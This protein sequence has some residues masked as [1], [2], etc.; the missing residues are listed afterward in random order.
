MQKKYIFHYDA[1]HAWLEVPIKDLYH[2]GVEDQI[3]GNSFRLYINAYL[4]QDCDANV[5]LGAAKSKGWKI[6]IEE[7]D[8]GDESPIR[9]YT[10]YQG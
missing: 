4:E 3:S 2:A 9:K 1:G 5:F 10:R 6:D 7:V 8:D